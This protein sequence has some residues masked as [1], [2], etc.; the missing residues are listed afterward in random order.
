[1][2]YAWNDFW[3]YSY[4][5]KKRDEY[6]K[7]VKKL[8]EYKENLYKYITECENDFSDFS[9]VYKDTELLSGYSFDDFYEKSSYI[10]QRVNAWIEELWASYDNVC[11]NLNKARNLYSQ[12][13]SACEKEDEEARRREAEGK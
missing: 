2:W 8:S 7:A 13:I 1:M 5:E 4:N 10:E 9:C 12:Y 3:D 11:N 6:K